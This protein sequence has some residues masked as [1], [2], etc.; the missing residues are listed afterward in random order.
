MLA[1]AAAGPLL[2]LAWGRCP[3]AELRSYQQAGLD[4]RP[5]LCA[6]D[7]VRPPLTEPHA[8]ASG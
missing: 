2:T 1:V 6:R 4:V 3:Q 7:S 5:R 8:P